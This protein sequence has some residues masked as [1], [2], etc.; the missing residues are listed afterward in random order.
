MRWA[1][2]LVD[3]PASLVTIWCAILRFYVLIVL[4]VAVVMTWSS[5]MAM[6][7]LWLLDI[8]FGW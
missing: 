6:L 5:L 2:W 7:V 1:Y 8:R 4:S 3:L